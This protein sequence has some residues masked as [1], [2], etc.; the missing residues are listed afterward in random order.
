MTGGWALV[1]LAEGEIGELGIVDEGV[2]QRKRRLGGVVD[3]LL[4]LAV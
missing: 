3:G 2:T 4:C 1:G